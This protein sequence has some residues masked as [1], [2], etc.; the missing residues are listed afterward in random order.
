MCYF[1]PVGHAV[2]VGVVLASV[3]AKHDL[4]GLG[5]PIAVYVCLH[6]QRPEQRDRQSILY[7]IAVGVN[8]KWVEVV[9]PEFIIICHP[10]SVRIGRN[11]AGAGLQFFVVE[12]PVS[13]KV[14]LCACEQRNTPVI[15]LPCVRE[16]VGVAVRLGRYRRCSNS[17]LDVTGHAV[18]VAVVGPRPGDRPKVVCLPVVRNKIV[19]GV[20][21]ATPRIRAV[22]V[23]KPVRYS[24]LV[25]VIISTRPQW[26][27]RVLHLPSIGHA[28]PVGVRVNRR[29]P[30][31]V[32]QVI[33]KPIRIRVSAVTRGAFR[34]IW[35]KPIRQF[36]RVR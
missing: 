33:R 20:G 12:Q 1:P 10:V 4:L 23:L 16:P 25:R 9:H 22:G 19:I 14:G 21:H 31:H 5:Q 34:R 7:P 35:V 18:R 29:R 8:S 28:V 11:R 15:T 2:P 17:I 36:P 6:A 32:L 3:R 24:V 27:K 26:V 13:V 30:K